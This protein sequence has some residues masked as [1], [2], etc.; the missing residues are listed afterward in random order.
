MIKDK[1]L[2]LILAVALLFFG[3]DKNMVSENDN[4]N[5]KSMSWEGVDH[6]YGVQ[7]RQ[8]EI[9]K[10]WVNKNGNVFQPGKLYF[11]SKPIN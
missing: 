2:Q 4:G 7:K 11:K 6:Y 10:N 5:L 8:I 9:L 1:G 3:C